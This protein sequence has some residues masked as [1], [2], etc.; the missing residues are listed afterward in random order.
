V[1]QAPVLSR[2]GVSRQRYDFTA[3]QGKI[4]YT[5]IITPHLINEA[6]IGIF[7]SELGPAED[8]LAYA[9][10]QKQYDRFAALGTCAPR[11]LPGERRP[12]VSRAP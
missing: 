5:R 11:R 7:Y 4:D 6:S 2:W 10:I 8:A 12:S 9:S 3:D 1:A